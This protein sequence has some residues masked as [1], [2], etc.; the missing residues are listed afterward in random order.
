M[1]EHKSAKKEPNF[2]MPLLPYD[3][4]PNHI[5]LLPLLGIAM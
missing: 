2:S 1:N 3:K 4:F 5:S